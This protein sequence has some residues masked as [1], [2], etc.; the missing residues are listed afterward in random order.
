MGRIA[1]FIDGAYLNFLLRDFGSPKI[2]YSLLVKELVGGRELLRAYYYDCL[3]Y[4]SSSPTA[5]EKERFGKKQKFFDALDRLSRFQT[6]LGRLEFRGKK[7]DGSPIFEQKR[8]DILL[9][10][11]LVLL[12][13]KHQITDAAIL[14]GDSDFLP[15]I[16]AAKPEGL[17]THLF[18]G[19]HP[20]R[21]LVTECDERCLIDS[22]F[23]DRIRMKATPPSF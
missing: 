10:V 20:H 18:H 12:A 6:R 17:V 15:A 16:Q 19:P 5:Q 13:A 7:D 8:V 2:D 14:A 3:P 9:G 1:I 11:D 21:D 22:D 23:I 4:Q